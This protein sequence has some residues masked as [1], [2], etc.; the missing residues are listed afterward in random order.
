MTPMNEASH[1]QLQP[2]LRALKEMI[3]EKPSEEIV[4]QLSGMDKKGLLDLQHALEIWG[5]IILRV[6]VQEKNKHNPVVFW[7]KLLCQQT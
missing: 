5:Y 2:T 6:V 1:I 3:G 7:N 4:K